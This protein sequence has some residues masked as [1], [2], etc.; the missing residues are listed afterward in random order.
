MTGSCELKFE[1]SR[2]SHVNL[3]RW[4]CGGLV[5]TSKAVEIGSQASVK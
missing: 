5:I 1:V 2:G 4:V 3:P